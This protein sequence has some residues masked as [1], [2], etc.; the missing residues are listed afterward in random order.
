MSEENKSK[1]RHGFVGEFH[2]EGCED[3]SSFDDDMGST[4]SVASLHAAQPPAASN[5]SS[6]R[7]RCKIRGTSSNVD[8]ILRK[9]SEVV[10][11][12]DQHLR[13]SGTIALTVW[14]E[15]EHVLGE[16]FQSISSLFD[17]SESARYSAEQRSAKYAI[18]LGALKRHCSGLGGAQTSMEVHR[19]AQSVFWM[20]K[21][22][23]EA[24]AGAKSKHFR[25]WERGTY[26]A[27]QAAQARDAAERWGREVQLFLIDAGRSFRGRN[28][29]LAAWRGLTQLSKDAAALHG[30]RRLRGALRAWRGA[31]ARLRWAESAARTS[32]LR[33]A[34]TQLASA[35]M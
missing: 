16:N 32:A 13:S 26:R 22:D 24:K 29:A 8:E 27:Q 20:H 34:A 11:G 14:S 31:P 23:S 21:Y 2:S 10:N 15:A 33:R 18:Q 9:Q 35:P 1:S 4:D 19:L 17:L 30:A 6:A 28:S 12:L 3:F 5:R 7:P 25:L